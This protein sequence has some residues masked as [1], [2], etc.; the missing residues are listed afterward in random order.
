MT[1]T[2]Q[3]P[4]Q[5][6][7]HRTAEG[8]QR[9]LPSAG[10]GILRSRWTRYTTTEGN[11]LATINLNCWRATIVFPAEAGPNTWDGFD[12]GT[13]V[14]PGTAAESPL[15]IVIGG[16]YFDGK[17]VY[18]NE[19]HYLSRGEVIVIEEFFDGAARPNN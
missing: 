3:F 2:R 6:S 4:P 11:V 17:P 10:G 15:K 5:R 16:A 8:H 1:R 19:V 13:I 18:L 9:G 14:N 7:A 12:I